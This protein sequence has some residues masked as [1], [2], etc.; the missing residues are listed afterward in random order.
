MT[1]EV[2]DGANVADP[3]WPGNVWNGF[4]DEVSLL[5]TPSGW[6]L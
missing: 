1:P 6:W 4:S 3:P 5:Q 2:M